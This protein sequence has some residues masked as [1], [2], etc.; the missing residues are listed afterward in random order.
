MRLSFVMS[1]MHV[2]G[3]LGLFKPYLLFIERILN[4]LDVACEEEFGPL[5]QDSLDDLEAGIVE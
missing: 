2:M 5:W 3:R 1:T 4:I